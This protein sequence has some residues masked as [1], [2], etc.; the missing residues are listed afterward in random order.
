MTVR[1]AS[2]AGMG[3]RFVVKV[4]VDSE[5]YRLLFSD[6]VGW[7]CSDNELVFRH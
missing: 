1:D 3:A 2:E 6:S 4:G 5:V 7:F